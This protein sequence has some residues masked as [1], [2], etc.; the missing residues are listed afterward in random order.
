[1]PPILAAYVY[2]VDQRGQQFTDAY[3]DI[4]KGLFEN[5][6]SMD[7]FK[8]TRVWGDS[9][10]AVVSPNILA[11]RKAEKPGAWISRSA[12]LALMDKTAREMGVKVAYNQNSKRLTIDPSTRNLELL[13]LQISEPPPLTLGPKP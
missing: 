11:T 9:K 8:S 7:L 2:L 13:T 6:I 12:F 4:T 5:G 3:G 10:G 1:M